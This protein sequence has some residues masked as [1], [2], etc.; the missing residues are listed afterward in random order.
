[1]GIMEVEGFTAI[2]GAVQYGKM[3][4][5]NPSPEGRG[6]REAAGEG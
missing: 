1:M 6:C 5:V 4:R 3:F 2:D